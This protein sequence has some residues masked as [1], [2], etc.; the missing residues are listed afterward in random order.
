MVLILDDVVK[1]G[2]NAG[3]NIIRI[4]DGMKYDE[5]RDT[6]N[7]LIN[8]LK[9]GRHLEFARKNKWLQK[10]SAEF[11]SDDNDDQ[12]IEDR[13][14]V[15]YLYKLATQTKELTDRICGFLNSF[16]GGY[17]LTAYQFFRFDYSMKELLIPV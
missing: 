3:Q 5:T 13:R 1:A 14:A 17:L 7:Q 10:H 16:V 15:V 8:A 2:L 12:G 6:L 4:K 9:S 11:L